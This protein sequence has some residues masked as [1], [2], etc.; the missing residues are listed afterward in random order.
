MKIVRTIA[1]NKSASDTWHALVDKFTPVD[2]WMAAITHSEEKTEGMRI[3]GAP[4]IGWKAFIG[5]N[6]GSYMDE[7]ITGFDASAMKFNVH[8]TLEGVGGPINGF[9][10][11]VSVVSLGEGQSEIIWDAKVLLK[12]MG[13]FLYPVIKKSL[14]AG[15]YRGLEE[16]KVF[17]ETGELHERAVEKHARWK[18]E[19]LGS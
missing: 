18:K 1:I 4:T 14:S 7:T 12:P 11:M 3:E 19:G 6:P 16:F 5:V 15:F 17:T 13:Y 10:Y 8:T 2:V 9:D